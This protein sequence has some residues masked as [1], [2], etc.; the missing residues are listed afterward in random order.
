MQ[1]IGIDLTAKWRQARLIKNLIQSEFWYRSETDANE[2]KK[3]QTGLYFLM[4]IQQ[5]N[6]QPPDTG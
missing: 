4:N 6:K 2:N 3:E 1:I 5:D